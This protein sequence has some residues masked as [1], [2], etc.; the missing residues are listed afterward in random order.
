[1][2]EKNELECVLT[3]AKVWLFAPKR[4]EPTF[5]DSSGFG[6]VTLENIELC[7]VFAW[8]SRLFDDFLGAPRL[9]F[10]LLSS[11]SAPVVPLGNGLISVAFL[12]PNDN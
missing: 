10:P 12:S 9:K 4:S 5:F 11:F 8:A 1:M 7:C 3:S 2:P 6:A